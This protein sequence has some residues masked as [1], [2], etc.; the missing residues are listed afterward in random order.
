M[1]LEKLLLC[2]KD[3]WNREVGEGSVLG[4]PGLGSGLE[5]W[6]VS[7]AFGIR[8]LTGRGICKK[9]KK[10]KRKTTLLGSWQE[11]NVCEM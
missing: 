7:P 5:A 9:K 6:C 8:E 10:E 1:Y 4:A 2:A 11:T 3:S